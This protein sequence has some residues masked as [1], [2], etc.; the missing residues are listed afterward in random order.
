MQGHANATARAVVHLRYLT[1]WCMNT[2]CVCA[3]GG[4]VLWQ[5]PFVVRIWRQVLR[6]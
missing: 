6:K 4:P 5:W 2:P 1:V 3:M